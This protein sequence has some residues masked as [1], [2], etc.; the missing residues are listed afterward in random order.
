MAKH[1]RIRHRGHR[2]FFGFVLL[3]DVR[4]DVEI[5]LFAGIKITSNNQRIDHF[6]RIVQFFVGAKRSKWEDPHKFQVVGRLVPA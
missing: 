6:D 3:D 5:I 1:V 4:Q 2:M